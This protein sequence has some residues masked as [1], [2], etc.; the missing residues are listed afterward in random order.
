[1]HENPWGHLC[2]FEH[3]A[4]N[5]RWKCAR[6]SFESIMRCSYV[7]EISRNTIFTTTQPPPIPIAALLFLLQNTNAISCLCVAGISAQSSMC[8]RHKVHC[9]AACPALPLRK[10]VWVF[11]WI[12]HVWRYFTLWCIFSKHCVPCLV[13]RTTSKKACFHLYLKLLSL[14]CFL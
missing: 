3:R 14:N 2:S 7:A 1:M 5:Y 12:L 10:H 13:H 9:W 4:W 8:V 6:T 11:L